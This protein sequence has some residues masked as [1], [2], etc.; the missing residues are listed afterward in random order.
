MRFCQV[1]LLVGVNKEDEQ[2]ADTTL[3]SC[4]LSILYGA[5]SMGVA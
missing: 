1:R 5:G 4:K 3:I 2:P